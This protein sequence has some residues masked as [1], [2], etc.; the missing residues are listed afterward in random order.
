MF[1]QSREFALCNPYA[2]HVLLMVS[3]L[4]EVL[5]SVHVVFFV[6]IREFASVLILFCAAVLE[7]SMLEELLSYL[8]E[9]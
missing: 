1:L 5:V 6:P 2:H 3:S 9:G 7:K 8:L 4:N